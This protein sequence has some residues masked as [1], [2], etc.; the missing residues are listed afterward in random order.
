[1]NSS[2]ATARYPAH[3]NNYYG[4]RGVAIDKIIVHHMA[5]VSTA[6]SCAVSFQNPNRGGS[7]NYCI[8]NDGEIAVSVDEMYASGASSSKQADLSGVT[9]ETS[10]S[11][12]GD[13]YGWPVSDKALKSLISLCADIAKRNN[14]GILVPGKNLCWHSMY[15]ATQCPGPYLLGKMQY[16]ADEA[17]AINT[18]LKENEHKL[19]GIDI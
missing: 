4:T 5:G 10:N 2:L 11:K 12:Y 15:G 3:T 16:I 9:I 13:A 8:G 18:P 6:K 7:S 17:N 19:D 1:M 14:L